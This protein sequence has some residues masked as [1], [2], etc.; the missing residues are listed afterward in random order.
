VYNTENYLPE[1]EEIILVRMYLCQ[2]WQKAK[3][4]SADN[5]FFVFGTNEILE[6]SEIY[7]WK[8]TDIENN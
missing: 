3:Y 4:N 7:D 8:H 6:A 5:T 1:S 2:E